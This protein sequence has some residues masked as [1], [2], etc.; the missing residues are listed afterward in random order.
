MRKQSLRIFLMIGLFAI[1]APL[2]VQAQSSSEQTASIPFSFNVGNKSFPA[3]EYRV[4]RINPASDKTALVIRSA[5]GRMSKLVLTMNVQDSKTHESAKLVFNRYG[6][7]YYLAQVWTPADNTG[8]ELPVSRS[9]RTLARN[10]GER[11]PE[12]TTV[13]L[14]AGR[15]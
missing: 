10:A 1:L 2:S 14:N 13:A 11:A 8:L 15:R 12:Q 7:Q 4:T 5:D 9:E 6:D 3:G